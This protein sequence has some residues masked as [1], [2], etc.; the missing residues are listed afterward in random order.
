[1]IVSKKK[2]EEK[3]QHVMKKKQYH[4]KYDDDAE[5]L[6]LIFQKKG[7]SLACM[8]ILGEKYRVEASKNLL[9]DKDIQ[10]HRWNC[11]V[12]AKLHDILG[13]QERF[14]L[15]G[16]NITQIF[17]LLSSNHVDLRNFL[18]R[19][20]EVIASE[21]KLNN[22]HGNGF[23]SR[24]VILAIK[25]DWE[26][27]IRL[28]N[29]WF[30]NPPKESRYKYYGLSFTFFNA[31]ARKDMEGMKTAIQTMLDPKVARSMLH[32]MHVF[33]DF[34]LHLYVIIYAKIALLHGIDLGIDCEVAPK[35]LIDNTPLEEYPQPYD[36]MKE[37]DIATA[38]GEDWKA[39]MISMKRL[40]TLWKSICA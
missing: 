21:R 1:M 11:F 19:N 27:V 34:Y 12:Y 39:W 17:C 25:G 35:E 18:V 8:R 15:L 36:F 23:L 6:S 16:G 31:L 30:E 2:Y 24:T 22:R 28:S 10:A 26:E 32:D 33:F 14:F 5:T 3:I 20:L 37:F 29:I 40:E 4:I 38:N 13:K 9:F 7:N